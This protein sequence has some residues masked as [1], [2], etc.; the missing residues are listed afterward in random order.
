[1]P[2]GSVTADGFKTI[3][4]KNAKFYQ[5]FERHRAF[6][7]LC[8]YL[9]DFIFQAFDFQFRRHNQS[10]IRAAGGRAEVLLRQ[11]ARQR[12]STG[13]K[14]PRRDARVVALGR[15]VGDGVRLR[16]GKW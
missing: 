7:N 8:L 12:R 9:G 4:F 16:R 10:L 14:F 1:M 13:K 6:F 2:Q 5:F 11:V 3:V 15:T